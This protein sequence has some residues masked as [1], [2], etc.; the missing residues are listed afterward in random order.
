MIVLSSSLMSNENIKVYLY[1]SQHQQS[2]H[3]VS[4]PII[5]SASMNSYPNRKPPPIEDNKDKFLV[6]RRS[7]VRKNSLIEASLSNIIKEERVG[8][9]GSVKWPPE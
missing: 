6:M 7:L 8:E 4:F 2:F 1:L 5:S 9:L 3:L